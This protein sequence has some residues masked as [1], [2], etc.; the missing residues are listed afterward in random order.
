LR[1][2]SRSAAACKARLAKLMTD[3][4]V[5]RFPNNFQNADQRLN[6]RAN[7]VSQLQRYS[8]LASPVDVKGVAYEE[9]V[10]RI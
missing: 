2:S 8:L 3:K 7:V 10:S 9:A 6:L 5:A 1:A 4:V